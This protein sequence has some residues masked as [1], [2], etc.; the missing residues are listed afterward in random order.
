M[1]SLFSNPTD[2][3]SL[4]G[5]EGKAGNGKHIVLLAADHEYRSEEYLPM[6][7]Q[8]L[9]EH[10]GFKTTTLFSLDD[11]GNVAPNSNKMPGME[12]LAEADAII[13]GLRFRDWSDA[14]FSHFNGALQRGVPFIATRTSTHA[15]KSNNPNWKKFSFNSKEKGWKGGFGRQVL[16]ETWVNH[17]GHHGKEGTMTVSEKGQENNPLLNGV[18][19][20]YGPTDV[21]GANPLNPEHIL[22]RGVITETMLPDSAPLKDSPKND[23]TMPVA[24]TKLYQNESGKT[25]KVFTTTLGS[26][27]DFLDEDLRRLM[28]N[29]TYWATDLEVPEK[30]EVSYVSAYEPQHFKGGKWRKET[31][32]ADLLE[33]KNPPFTLPH[34][35]K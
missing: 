20:I 10:H 30:A 11:Q 25:N 1:L 23:P 26:G 13:L 31:K 22:L 16:G 2:R 17:H 3:I 33:L 4:T 9:S 8:I 21:Y 29:A 32:P 15:F 28:V 19:T 27:I 35:K 34:L 7:A 18:G 5:A 14:D 12:V 6:L 24:W